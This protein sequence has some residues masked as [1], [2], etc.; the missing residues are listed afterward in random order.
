MIKMTLTIFTN[1]EEARSIEA[2]RYSLMR[3]G[4]LF[5]SD[6]LNGVI[7]GMADEI[8]LGNLSPN[9]V[10]TAFGYIE[11]GEKRGLY[12]IHFI[13]WNHGFANAY[14]PKEENPELSKEWLERARNYARSTEPIIEHR[15]QLAD[16][17]EAHRTEIGTFLDEKLKG[18]I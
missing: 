8:P 10:P 18:K 17:F 11:E 5:I 1:N 4:D 6:Q 16:F 7:I 2:R 9:L 15:K 3:T 14:V 12:G 13:E